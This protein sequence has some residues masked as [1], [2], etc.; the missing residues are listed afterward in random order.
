MSCQV[1]NQLNENFF[2][3]INGLSCLMSLKCE[4]AIYNLLALVLYALCT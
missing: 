1:S 2:F 4:H 3:L